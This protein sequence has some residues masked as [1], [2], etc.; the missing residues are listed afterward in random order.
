MAGALKLKNKATRRT[1]KTQRRHKLL[2]NAQR[3]VTKQ[4]RT[5][6][7]KPLAILIAEQ[8]I[9]QLGVV[10]GQRAPREGWCSFCSR[11]G[12]FDDLKGNI[13]RGEIPI[14]LIAHSLNS[15]NDPNP[16][17]PL[18][19]SSSSPAAAPRRRGKGEMVSCWEC[20]QS[21]HFS[22]MELNNLTIKSHVKSYPWLCLEC[23]RCHGCDKKGDNDHNM[24]LCAVCDRGWHGECLNPPLKIVPSGDFTCPFDHQSTQCISPLP[25]SLTLPPLSPAQRAA[26][27]FPIAAN[28][29][30]L[31]ANP[32]KANNNRATVTKKRKMKCLRSDD[33]DESLGSFEKDGAEPT[34]IRA[35]KKITTAG[36]PR[37]G[38]KATAKR[39]LTTSSSLSPL[40]KQTSSSTLD[41][42]SIPADGS[43]G[44][45]D[46]AQ[47]EGGE[48]LYPAK[49][50]NPFE[51]VLTEEEAAIGDRIICEEDLLRF[52]QSLE[53]S[54]VRMEALASESAEKTSAPS[55]S[56]AAGPSPSSGS[57]EV[58]RLA[59]VRDRRSG[60]PGTSP[61]RGGRM[62]PTVSTPEIEV[63][64]VS[65]NSST[66]PEEPVKKK[67]Q[68]IRK[69][70]RGEVQPTS[71]IKSIRFGE[72]EIDV[73]YQAPYPEEYSKLP[74][75]RLWICERCLKYFKTE[76]EISRH[77]MKC[78]NFY[79]PGDEIYRDNDESHGVR[80]QIFEVDGRKNKMYCQNL[81]L[82]SKMFL[83]HKTLYYDVDPFLFYVITQTPI[84]PTSDSSAPADPRCQFVGYFSKEKRSPT[85]NVSC[86]MTLPVLQRKGWGNLLIDFSYLLSKKEK[87]VGTPEK[88]L[89]DLGLLSYRNYWTLTIAKFLLK[90]DPKDQ[91]T[92]ED[93]ANETSISLLDVYYT[94]RHKRWIE[95]VNPTPV[96]TA[97]VAAAAHTPAPKRKSHNW[98]G[99]RKVPAPGTAI[100]HQGSPGVV[101]ENQGPQAGG[102]AEKGTG[103]GPKLVSEREIP[104]HYRIVWTPSEVGELVD[105]AAQKGLLRLRPDKLRWSP[106]LA[107]RANSLSIDISPIAIPLVPDT[108]PYLPPASSIIAPSSAIRAGPSRP[109]VVDLA[110]N[111]LLLERTNRLTLPADAAS[112]GP[113]IPIHSLS[114]QPLQ[115]SINS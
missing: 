66:H 8:E 30:P 65:S 10:G 92:L 112:L 105:R 98:N 106:F 44:N 39:L 46:D 95:D 9:L 114:L 57:L 50:S 15:S 96:S 52:K 102:G 31:K 42:L 55:P 28:N 54:K 13:V 87:R 37:N 24:L 32:T 49:Q 6:N 88:P 63:D 86:I 69:S 101:G 11:E 56:M 4:K 45:M 83:D 38:T 85:N 18:P 51:G 58:P 99:R 16:I 64:E 21:G 110:R 62:T 71:I 59:A 97:P 77:R 76:F 40:R 93:I 115:S 108:D 14:S 72:Y 20:G 104:K 34:E 91:V 74:D 81:C 36:K 89:S 27:S 109:S 78:K 113:Q 61:S 82:L 70:R 12:G 17:D 100:V 67:D 48:G 22:C 43:D 84:S 25:D 68:P 103:G 3:S 41:P 53:R 75:G 26:A 19:G 60:V 33:D 90:S 5:T 79:P 7:P 23:R 107:A 2:S 47:D 111:K 29:T 35:S 73:W 1:P 94:C 80:I